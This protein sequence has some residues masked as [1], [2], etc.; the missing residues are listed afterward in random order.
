VTAATVVGATVVGGLSFAFAFAFDLVGAFF[1]VAVL[2]FDGRSA[3]IMFV[4]SRVGISYVKIR[5]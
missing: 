5:K 3:S 1:L 2:S 4:F